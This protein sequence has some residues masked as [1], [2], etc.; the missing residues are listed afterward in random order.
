MSVESEKAI[1]G[2]LLH[3]ANNAKSNM[4]I[5]DQLLSSLVFDRDTNRQLLA[6]LLASAIIQ[7]REEDALWTLRD[8]L[9]ESAKLSGRSKQAPEEPKPVSEY[10]RP[11]GEVYYA[12]PWGNH[13]DVQV[14]KQAREAMLPVLLT[15][16]PGTGKTAM[17]EAAFGTELITMVFSG[18]TQVSGI[19]GGF[20]PNPNPA[21]AAIRPYVWVDGPLL[22]A[23]REGRPFLGDEIGLADPK[24]LSPLYPLMDGRGFLDVEDNPDI[25]TVQAAPGFYIIGAVN[26]K[27]PGVRMS[28]ALISRFPIQAEVT[29]DY[30]LAVKLGV[31]SNI[32]GLAEGLA[33]QMRTNRVSWAPQMR[34][35]LFYR[36]IEKKWGSAFA[37]NNLLSACPEKDREKLA[38]MLRQS[39]LSDKAKAARI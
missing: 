4:S 37:L 18:D 39:G 8:R 28:E 26:P 38:I 30:P 6:T 15:G 5:G 24:V 3:H 14:L 16:S 35:L 19:V 13:E 1:A 23:V 31:N 21:D 25:G 11:N 34:E 10:V 17:A 32:V 9:V 2:Y 20:I 27:A 7:D 22:V 33:N 36:D 29:T 12:R